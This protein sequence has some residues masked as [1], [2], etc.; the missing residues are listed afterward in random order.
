MTTRSW[1]RTSLIAVV[2]PTSTTV[3]PSASVVVTVVLVLSGGRRSRRP[4][5]GSGGQ[6]R[7]PGWRLS[8]RWLRRVGRAERAQAGIV[9]AVAVR[10][11]DAHSDV[12]TLQLRHQ[13][14]RGRALVGE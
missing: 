6:G 3:F 14:R 13:L 12:L 5:R 2:S 9:V 1:R 10:G 4:L 11:D 8:W 7:L